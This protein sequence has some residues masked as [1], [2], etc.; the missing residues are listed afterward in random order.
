[1]TTE[2]GAAG[3]ST[4]PADVKDAASSRAEVY[5]AGVSIG[6]ALQSVVVEIALAEARGRVRVLARL[7]ERHPDLEQA[8][9][10]AFDRLSL[11]EAR[12]A[13]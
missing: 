4:I 7:A 10:A 5:R 11:L 2:R 12:G 3:I 6:H 1:M 9:R 13:A 8:V